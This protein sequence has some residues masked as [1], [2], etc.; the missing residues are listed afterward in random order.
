MTVYD[1]DLISDDPRIHRLD[2]LLKTI[3]DEVLRAMDRFAPFNSPHEGYAV[4]KE[5]L[6]ELWEECRANRGR[7]ADAHAEAKQIAA[8]AVR[9]MLDLGE[10]A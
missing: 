4:I 8:M 6:D 5:E 7:S 3:G 9:Y 1:P 2:Y 10:T